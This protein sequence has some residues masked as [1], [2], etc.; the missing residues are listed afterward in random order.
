MNP[1]EEANKEIL[2]VLKVIKK[3]IEIR[4]YGL[5]CVID[6]N[7]P[8]LMDKYP[9]S[10]SLSN[11]CHIVH[12]QLERRHKVLEIIET[13]DKKWYEATKFVLE[14]DKPKFEKFY[15]RFETAELKREVN[16]NKDKSSK[17]E[18]RKELNGVIKM[19]KFGTMEKKFLKL[20]AKDF[21]PKAIKEIAREISTKDCKHVRRRADAK[22]KGTGFSIKTIRAKIWGGD[23]FYQLKHSTDL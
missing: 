10:P 3:T 5:I 14:V 8:E 15:E 9:G 1:I 22:I 16:L 7:L 19:G 6:I 18:I 20:L 11:I 23:S 21:R 17:R 13:Y 12:S 2:W 4:G